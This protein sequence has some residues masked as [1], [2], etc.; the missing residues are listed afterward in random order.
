V[1]AARAGLVSGLSLSMTARLQIRPARG[2]EAAALSELCVR[3]KAVWGYDAAFMALAAAALAIGEAEIGAGAVWVAVTG[4]E[5]AGV[6]ALAPGAAPGTLDL[7]RLFVAPERLRCGVGRALFAHVVAEARR[8]GAGRL[9]ILAD[10]NAGGFYERGGARRIG[11]APSDAVAGRLL[12]LYEIAL[13][14]SP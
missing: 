3:S 1:L 6:A 2:G 10:P 7:A 13:V 12:P 14:P 9:T 4:E 5:I 11:A 8:Q